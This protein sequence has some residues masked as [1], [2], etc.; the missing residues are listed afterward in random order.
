VDLV[1]DS[2]P[3]THIYYFDY[4][5]AGQTSGTTMRYYYQAFDGE[6]TVKEGY[7]TYYEITWS[8]PPVTVERPIPPDVKPEIPA[9]EFTNEH[10]IVLMLSM[11]ILTA[12]VY[13]F[14][15]RSKKY[16]RVE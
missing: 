2:N 6:N 10:L 8:Y 13:T 16:S 1:Y 9:I 15:Q 7:P 14:M 3:S 4:L 12:T 11:F 5:F